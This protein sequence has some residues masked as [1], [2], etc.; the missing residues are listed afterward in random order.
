MRVTDRRD[1][2]DAVSPASGDEN[3]NRSRCAG[4]RRTGHQWPAVGR[5]AGLVPARPMR[6]RCSM[7]MLLWPIRR[8]H[9]RPL[10]GPPA[11]PSRAARS[12]D[13]RPPRSR[14]CSVP[15]FL[16]PVLEQQLDG[17]QERHHD[18]DREPDGENGKPDGQGDGQRQCDAPGLRDRL[19]GLAAPANFLYERSVVPHHPATQPAATGTGLR[20]GSTSSW[21]QGATVPTGESSGSLRPG[22]ASTVGWRNATPTSSGS[23]GHGSLVARVTRD[24]LVA[25]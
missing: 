18:A 10:S 5:R 3:R 16:E 1:H 25:T 7:T 24:H 15:P 8:L 12:S 21:A 19:D 22:E 23:P 4:R 20:P 17:E 9:G 2:A 14:A 13:V 11:R 6:W